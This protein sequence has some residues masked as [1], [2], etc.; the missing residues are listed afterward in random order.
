MNVA[1]A[2]GMSFRKKIEGLEKLF[3]EIPTCSM[4]PETGCDGVSIRNDVLRGTTKAGVTV[5]SQSSDVQNYGY[6]LEASSAPWN[7]TIT[8]M[9]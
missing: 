8:G 3:L 2:V 7:A 5:E 6:V 9:V 4:S 1:D